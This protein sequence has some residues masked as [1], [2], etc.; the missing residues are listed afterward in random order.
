MIWMNRICARVMSGF[1]V[2]PLQAD[3]AARIACKS[4]TI[5]LAASG[6]VADVLSYLIGDANCVNERDS[7]SDCT[8]VLLHLCLDSLPILCCILLLNFASNF[9]FQWPIHRSASSCQSWSTGSLRAADCR[10]S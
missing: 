5:D 2:V 8:R 10:Q 9:L 1:V 4:D 7:W 3:A 6:G